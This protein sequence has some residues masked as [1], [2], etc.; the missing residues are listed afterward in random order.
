[1]ELEK[2]TLLGPIV[3]GMGAG[4][5]YSGDDLTNSRN[6]ARAGEVPY[7]A[8]DGSTKDTDAVLEL[9]IHGVG[10]A[11]ATDNLETPSTLQVAG[12]GTAGFH[13]AWYPGGNALG[14]PRRE[15]YCWGGLNTRA[16]SRAFYL[17]L[18]AFMLIN[19]AHWAL[20]G[21]KDDLLNRVARALLRLLGL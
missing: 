7:L 4:Q 1:M 18:I 20:P 2:D 10:G 12:D 13:R 11:P 3:I 21:R 15:A 17:L 9:R 16:T 5:G 19:V 14:R 8:A 6:A